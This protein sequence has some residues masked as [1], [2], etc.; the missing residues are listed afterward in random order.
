MRTVN[1]IFILAGFLAVILASGCAS[2]K[3]QST[4]LPS[5]D[6]GGLKDGLKF[7]IVNVQ[8]NGTAAPTSSTML[9]CTAPLLMESAVRLHPE[10][11]SNSPSAIPLSV[12]IDT[13]NSGEG[14]YGREQ[15]LQVLF[16]LLGTIPVPESFETVFNV[17]V[18][19]LSPVPFLNATESFER[20]DTTWFTVLTPL[21]LL[22][23]PGQSD[24]PRVIHLSSETAKPNPQTPQFSIDCCSEAVTRCVR[25]WNDAQIR[26]VMNGKFLEM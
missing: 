4:L 23:V 13:V 17:Q 2:T 24:L 1:L 18:C 11:F 21:G 14:L 7:N 6:R 5:P 26:N 25:Q 9:T 10:L 16:S 8:I 3:I 15:N 20:C 19:D 22:P 12:R